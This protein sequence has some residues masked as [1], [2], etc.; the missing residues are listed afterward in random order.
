MYIL[1]GFAWILGYHRKKGC[2]RYI[3][4]GFAWILGYHRKKAVYGTEL[5][6]KKSFQND[7][8]VRFFFLE[9]HGRNES[10]AS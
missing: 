2:V 10:D 9:I 8:I 4:S 1:S 3:L 5:L 6:E 7:H